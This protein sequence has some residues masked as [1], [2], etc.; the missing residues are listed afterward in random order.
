MGLED[1]S[2]AFLAHVFP[3]RSAAMERFRS[4]IDYL[5]QYHRHHRD[6]V[7]TVLLR[8]ETGVG[9]TYAAKAIS[10][11]STWLT[12][13]GTEVTRL[14]IDPEG[15]FRLPAPKL[16]EV[17]GFKEV[18]EG[19]QTRSV[20]RLAT[21]P[22]P[23]VVDE[24]ADSQ[25]FGHVKGTF[26]GADRD[27]LGIFGDSSVEDVL[28]DEIGDISL[29]VQAKLL[30]FIETRQYRRVGSAASEERDS[31]HR[32]FLAT[33]RPLEQFVAEN[34]FRED[35]YWRIQS[36][37][38]TIP[39][40]RER[41]DVIEELAH[42]IL[43]SINY[44]HRG[45]E[46][47]QPSK[48]RTRERYRLLPESEQIPRREEVSNWVLR[49][50]E[51]DITWCKTQAW[52]GNVRELRHCI[53]QYVFYDGHRRLKDVLAPQRGFPSSATPLPCTVGELV[54][55]AV[56]LEV[57]TVLNGNAAPFGTPSEYLARFR[58]HVTSAF[59]EVKD[60]CNLTPEQI[61]R[62]FPEAKDPVSTISRW[63]R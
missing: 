20:L 26:T 39:P 63:R 24:L 21:V 62:L 60:R 8:G 18:N 48:D 11:H 25:L 49:F 52:P 54:A 50:D 40:L 7:R 33:N 37:V 45:E 51:D 2:M 9:K 29:G 16:I 22:G 5:N 30:H 38:I 44:Q 28:L 53:D 41:L 56:E 42:S 27:S 36:H 15:R 14:Y 32:L 6:A 1:H 10:A 35:L 58:E 61:H 4:E 23:Q 55:R 12:L 17:L 46:R 13:D 57:L 31:N 43:K 34:R 59:R 19:K 3:G 47:R